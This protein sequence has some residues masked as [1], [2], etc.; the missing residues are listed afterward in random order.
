M[1][2]QKFF[3]CDFEARSR[4]WARF[5]KVLEK[6]RPIFFGCVFRKCIL[7]R[8]LA[9]EPPKMLK[10]PKCVDIIGYTMVLTIL[11]CNFYAKNT[12]DAFKHVP[13]LF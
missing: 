7:P 9:K 8:G 3:W 5:Q 1:S 2:V 13:D 12:P 6:Q 11:T 4:V 10:I